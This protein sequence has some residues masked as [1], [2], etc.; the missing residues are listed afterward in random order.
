M[1]SL[2]QFNDQS[3]TVPVSVNGTPFDLSGVSL[4]EYKLYTESKTNVLLELDLTSG[5]TKI[6]SEYLITITKAQ[7]QNLRGEFY[8]E[9]VME[10]PVNLRSTVFKALITFE[11]TEN[12]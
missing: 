6:G 4:A 8:H 3:I 2:L 7:S 10:D 5:I 1:A 11:A 9:M 12:N